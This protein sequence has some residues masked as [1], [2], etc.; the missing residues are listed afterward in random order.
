LVFGI[1]LSFLVPP[2]MSPDEHDH[3][4]RAYS[5]AHGQLMLSPVDAGGNSGGSVDSGLLAYLQAYRDIFPDG[6]MTSRHYQDGLRA[7]W[8][9]KQVQVPFPGAGFYLPAI[10]LPH[11]I[12]IWIGEGLRLTIDTTYRLMRIATLALALAGLTLSFVIAWPNAIVLGLLVL[13]MSLFQMVSPTIDGVALMLTTLVLSTFLRLWRDGAGAGAS[14]RVLFYVSL[15]VL[16]NSRAQA[17]PL[18]LLPFVLFWGNRCKSD[19]VAGM[20]QVVLAAGWILIAARYNVDARIS[21]T[22]GLRGAVLHY[23]TQP[24]ELLKVLWHTISSKARLQF[25]WESFVGILG[26]L[27]IR[28]PRMFYLLSGAALLVLILCGVGRLS[29]RRDTIASS[30]LCLTALAS[31]VIVFFAMLATWTSQPA[32]QI[33]GVQGRYLMQPALILGY[34]MVL[35]FPSPPRL[36]RG[37]AC[38]VLAGYFALSVIVTGHALLGRYWIR[39]DRVSLNHDVA[40]LNVAPMRLESG[41]ILQGNLSPL[42]TGALDSVILQVGTYGNRARGTVT[43]RVCNGLVC[44]Q[45]KAALATMTDNGMQS[46]YLD[47]PI[48]VNRGDTI[49]FWVQ[50]D[51]SRPGAIWVYSSPA[52]EAN[53]TLN[54]IAQPYVLR[55]SGEFSISTH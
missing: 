5:V 44:S 10:Y 25:Y 31:L 41:A 12:A 38:I 39:G 20:L 26:W 29:S 53:V 3:V 47:Q 8:T 52:G 37:V 46:F 19:G 48:S 7:G 4:M 6:R 11:A 43:V 24:V 18:L 49:T 30:I 23:G 1:A 51:G 13:P 14:I 28:L 17:L 35:A 16:V 15:F 40:G 27:D 50:A 32:A 9:G 42:V 33:E 2:D 22:L 34:A 21:N 36:V 55:A 45:G 54:G